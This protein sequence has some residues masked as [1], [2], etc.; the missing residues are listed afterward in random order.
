M[1]SG[2]V[3]VMSWLVGM[4]ITE[5]EKGNIFSLSLFFNIYFLYMST[6]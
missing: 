3:I 4:G 1:I 6:L 5:E 2:G